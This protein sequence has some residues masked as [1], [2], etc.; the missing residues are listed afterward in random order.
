LKYCRHQNNASTLIQR[1]LAADGVDGTSGG[2]I[3]QT[4]E[5]RSP[6]ILSLISSSVMTFIGCLFVFCK[7]DYNLLKIRS[8]IINLGNV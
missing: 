1:H 8:G 7:N 6:H 4:V 3:I 2:T 5:K